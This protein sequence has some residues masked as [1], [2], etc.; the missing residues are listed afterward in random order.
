MTTRPRLIDL[1]RS[2]V[3]GLIAVALFGIMTAVFMATGFGNP[4]EFTDGVS[5]VSGIGY[6][7]LGAP[8]Q[9]TVN[10]DTIPTENFLVAFILIAVLLDAALD[11]ALML[12]RRDEGGDEQ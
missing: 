6:A 4:S 3:P 5:I 2:I 1:D 9:V 12:A 8:E 7:L 11:G 10:S